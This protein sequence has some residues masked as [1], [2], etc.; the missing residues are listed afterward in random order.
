MANVPKP[1]Y[2]CER[3]KKTLAEDKFYK[4]KDG[5][6]CEL[7]KECLTAH[8]KNF[9]PET[10]TWILEK[11]DVP[12]V[13]S[14][15]NTLRDR[16]YV[17]DPKKIGGPAVMGRYL[18]SMKL[19]QWRDYSWKDSDE[20]NKNIE[21]KAKNA[22]E[23][24]AQEREK[25]NE[26]LRKDFE[27][28]NISQAEYET[29]TSVDFQKEVNDSLG[30][31]LPGA[32]PMPTNIP[33]GNLEDSFAVKEEDLPS[34]ELTEEDK[35]RLALKWGRLYKP[36]EWIELEQ[37]YSDMENSFD[38][39][40]ADTRNT[41]ILMCKTDLKMNQ[42]LDMGDID[43]YQ[44]LARVSS[45]LRKSSKFTAAQNKDKDADNIDCTGVLVAVCERKTGFIPTFYDMEKNDEPRDMIDAM[46]QDS[47]NYLKK[48]T[49][50]AGFSQQIEIALK[51]LALEKE[52]QET[53]AE[54][55]EESEGKSLFDITSDDLTDKDI[56]DYYE[57]IEEQR[58]TDSQL[59]QASNAFER[60]KKMRKAE[61]KGG[62]TNDA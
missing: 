29:L 33:G 37:K 47:H 3:C 7:C 41:L 6:V 39:Q 51:K 48:L 25:R 40:D 45:D 18:S 50:D 4:Y 36:N 16:A 22:T 57:D 30:I 26:A 19:V 9:E 12:Y 60:F 32:I 8:V 21:Q 52:A 38:I 1:K 28:G 27:E 31:N 17:K 23:E 58:E 46:I 14:Q 5:S 54:N 44:K 56:A 49:D 2:Y 20:L 35:I 10:F 24:Q 11:F 15:W 13:I 43:S 61:I 34:V 55:A 42:A 62:D 59:T 53:A